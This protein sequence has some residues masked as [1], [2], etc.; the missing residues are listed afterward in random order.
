MKY[1]VRFEG[2]TVALPSAAMDVIN[3]A[4]ACELRV[5][6]C[7]CGNRESTDIKTLARLTGCDG[8]EVRDA[9]AFL[10]GAGLIE[11]RDDKKAAPK[12]KAS[13]KKGAD[14]QTQAEEADKAEIAR[15]K[16]LQREEELPNYTSAQLSNMLETRAD[17]VTLVDEGQNILGKMFNYKEVNVLVGLVDYL[18]LDQEYILILMSHCAS[19]GKKTLHYIEK[20]AFGL[21]DDGI[22]TSQQLEAELE[23]RERTL[24]IEGK[25]RSLFGL[26][27][28]ALTTKE[29]KFISAWVSDFGYGED[30]I[31]KAYE[32]TADATGNASMPYANSVLERWN[33]QGLK[34]LEDIEASYQKSKAEGKKHEGS[35]D[36]DEFFEAAVRRALGNN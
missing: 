7:L 3:R 33:A 11:A 35:F 13:A 10:R 22:C 8:D 1:V 15:A 25:I 29:K 28:R 2:D 24:A 36:T 31:S 6:L 18:G 16:K 27:S 20:T 21:Y 32:V 30:I 17:I 5:L 14:E 19:Q 23:R 26:G 12:K 34:T 4:N 9:I